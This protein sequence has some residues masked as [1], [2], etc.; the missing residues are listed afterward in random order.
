M[1]LSSHS[2][3]RDRSDPDVPIKAYSIY[4]DKYS[5]SNIELDLPRLSAENNTCLVSPAESS[6]GFV[7]SPSLFPIL[8]SVTC[9]AV[10][11]LIDKPVSQELNK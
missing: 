10:L 9:P 1:G 3:S 11:S 7:P 6:S 5:W 4:L 2:G 8:S